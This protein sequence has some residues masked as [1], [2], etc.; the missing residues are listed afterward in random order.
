MLS[1]LF[2]PRIS[3]RL[4]ATAMPRAFRG[5]EARVIRSPHADIPAIPNTSVTE[6]ILN[7]SKTYSGLPCFRTACALRLLT[8]SQELRL[9]RRCNHLWYSLTRTYLAASSRRRPRST[10]WVLSAATCSP[11]KI[12]FNLWLYA[13]CGSHSQLTASPCSPLTASTTP[14]CSTR[15]RF[16]AL[17]F[18]RSRPIFKWLSSNS[19]FRCCY[20][21]ETSFCLPLA[22]PYSAT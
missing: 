17:L 11:C 18:L 15:A 13:S 6:I 20:F 4:F 7:K 2:R 8:L 16:P 9:P 3:C 19:S 1:S 12:F 22:I 14:S 21:T 5:D 10:T